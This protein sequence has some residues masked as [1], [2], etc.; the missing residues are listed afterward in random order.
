MSYNKKFEAV[1]GEDGVIELAEWVAKPI[2]S[3]NTA[4]DSSIREKFSHYD[5]NGDGKLHFMELYTNVRANQNRWSNFSKLWEQMDLGSTL[6]ASVQDA[7]DGL[8]RINPDITAAEATALVSSYDMSGDGKI[9]KLD[10]W[11]K[12]VREWEKEWD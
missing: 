2:F 12:Q 6:S 11:A 1:A 7:I 5:I 3:A 4:S 9:H 10:M 8:Q